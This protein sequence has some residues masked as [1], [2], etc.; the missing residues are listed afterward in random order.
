MTDAA[1]IAARRRRA[2]GAMRARGLDGL[3]VTEKFNYW[4]LTGHLSR[5]FDK[6][7]RVLALVLPG[8]GGA[9]LVLPENEAGAA[10]RTCPED[11]FATY[12]D[13]P[14]DAALL[15]QALRGAGLGDARIGIEA[16][17]NDRLGIALAQLDV[18]RAA[19][20]RATFVDSGDLFDRLRMVKFPDEIAAIR[21]ACRISLA[22]WARTL[23]QLRPG[24]TNAD[25]A[26]LLGAELCR[27][28]HDFNAPG[29]VTVGNGVA[30][31]AATVAATCCGPISAPPGGATRPTCRAAR[32]SARR[33][34]RSTASTQTP[35]R[36][37]TR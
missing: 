25:I 3:L 1:A 5:E 36:C 18:L 8:D 12:A 6:K 14:F 7:M 32:C 37:S 15:A 23:P 4:H 26:G 27:G 20:P 10:A 28:G 21:E 17:A 19:L 33:A 30:G 16:G 11:A 29:H 9:T 24:L 31:A 22:A 2:R 13:V 34:R 35:A